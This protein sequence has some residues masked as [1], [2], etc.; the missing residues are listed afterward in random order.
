M[1]RKAIKMAVLSDVHLG[2][3]NTPTDHICNAI[4]QEFL[5]NTEVAGSDII[6]ISGDF[7]HQLLDL[8]TSSSIDIIAIISYMLR[9]C[10]TRNIKL[11]VLKGTGSHDY[12]QSQHFISIAKHNNIPV[13][14]KYFNTLDI[15]YIAEWDINILYIPDEFRTEHSQTLVEVKALLIERNLKTVDIGIMHGM[16]EQQVP[17]CHDIPY[18]DSKEYLAIVTGLIFIGH[19]HK[20]QSYKRITIPGSFDRLAQG[21]EH[22]KGFLTATLNADN[23]YKVVFHENT[24]ARKYLTFTMGDI[25]SKDA[26]AYISDRVDL[27][28]AS[29][30]IRLI[31]KDFISY[32]VILKHCR[33]KYP[34]HTWEV[35]REV[36]KKDKEKT[37]KEIASAI[38]APN[39]IDKNNIAQELAS[40]LSKIHSDDIVLPALALFKQEILSGL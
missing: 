17:K 1:N 16:F 24:L 13:D 3:P 20:H 32:Q 4:I 34:Q 6:F 21:E 29:A 31:V 10:A 39:T 37:I 22:A 25:D 5:S 36:K 26:L 23:S 35:E 38:Q 14:L 7:Y 9:Y 33:Y 12:D 8:S 28:S 19:D 18:H 11:R 27:L 2:H 15:E 30:S 40:R